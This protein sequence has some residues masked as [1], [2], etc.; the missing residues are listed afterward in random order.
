MLYKYI[1]TVCG[2][3]KRANECLES[4]TIKKVFQAL[5]FSEVL[6]T[7]LMFKHTL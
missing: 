4:Y 2:L 5:P 6:A 1:Y 3:D 7:L